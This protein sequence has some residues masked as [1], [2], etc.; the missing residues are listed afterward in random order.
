MRLVLLAAFAA[1]LILFG[2]VTGNSPDQPIETP[3]A[4][5]VAVPVTPSVDVPV[6]VPVTKTS[7][8]H[9]KHRKHHHKHRH[10]ARLPESEAPTANNPVMPQT[11]DVGT[12]CNLT[13]TSFNAC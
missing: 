12:G 13:G 5:S 11:P 6:T 2:C 8:K 4:P 3:A 7:T 10:P 1:A 9:H